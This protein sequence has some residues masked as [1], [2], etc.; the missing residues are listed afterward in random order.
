MGKSKTRGRLQG[1]RCQRLP[2]TA[3][4]NGVGG[5]GPSITF[6]SSLPPPSASLGQD[7]KAAGNTS[8][9]SAWGSQTKQK[10]QEEKGDTAMPPHP[11]GMHTAKPS[12]A[13]A[14]PPTPRLPPTPQGP[15]LHGWEMPIGQGL[16]SA[17]RRVSQ[18]LAKVQEVMLHAVLGWV[19][20]QGFWADSVVRGGRDATW[21]RCCS[22]EPLPP[23]PKVCGDP[24]H[25]LSPRL[26]APGYP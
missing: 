18:L 23:S 10:P 2:P 21:I 14:G 12:L 25:W 15:R 1:C 16:H 5:E 26:A 24:S 7:R 17:V 20:P 6:A 8:S 19:E 11:V 4:Y 9:A 13:V 3:W 22:A